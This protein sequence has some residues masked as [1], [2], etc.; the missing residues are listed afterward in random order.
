MAVKVFRLSDAS[1]TTYEQV[2]ESDHTAVTKA[3]GW[4]MGKS[5]IATSSEMDPGVEQAAATFTANSSSPKPSQLFSGGSGTANAF[6]SALQL[7]GSFANT[8]WTFVV[9]W[10]SVTTA[11][12][13]TVRVRVRVF[14][15][16]ASDGTLAT[17]LTSSTQVGSTSATGSTTV[18]VSSTVTW[19]PGGVMSFINEF[20]YVACALE[21]VTASGSNTADA[22]LRSG[23]TTSVG[24]RFTTPDFTPTPPRHPGVNFQNP[25][26]LAKTWERTRGRIFIP[27]LWLPNPRQPLPVL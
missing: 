1:F 5:A 3:T 27:D 6:R 10:R 2:E 25:G 20:L 13:G 9:V 11:H 21:V 26:V 16:L 22:L 19:S 4:T 7:H 12:T 18:D 17:E 14:R 8:D 24:T 23:S 15:S